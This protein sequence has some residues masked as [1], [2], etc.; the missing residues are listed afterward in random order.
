MPMAALKHI[1][2]VS[3]NITRSALRSTMVRAIRWRYSF[4]TCR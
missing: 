3:D 2:S 1:Y 4:S